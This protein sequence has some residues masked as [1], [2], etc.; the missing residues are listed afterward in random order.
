MEVT[1]ELRFVSGEQLVH[2][3][4]ASPG[5]LD[6]QTMRGVR[7]LTPESAAELERLL[8]SELASTRTHVPITERSRP[9]LELHEDYSREVVHDIF[10]PD[11]PFTPQRGTWS[12]HGIVAI[13][14]RAGDY[15]FFVTL[16]QQGEHV[17][18]AGIT[19]DGVLSWQSQPRQGLRN[20]Q[21][22]EW[23]CVGSVD[24]L[25][26]RTVCGKETGC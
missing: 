20:S 3:R 14:D 18:D 21:I 12:L 15:V 16:G 24:C 26:L 22:Q 6:Q 10:A 2:P 19:K 7:E 17:F 9:R 1:Q 25:R 23:T 4:F 8:L 11:S 13:P 5:R